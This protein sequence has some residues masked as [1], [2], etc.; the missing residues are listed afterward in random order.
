ME[1]TLPVFKVE[2]AM[3]DFLIRAD[4]QPRGDFLIYL[5]DRAYSYLRFDEVTLL[6]LSAGYQVSTIRQPYLSVNRRSVIYLSVLSTEEA[7]QL[8]VLQTK[9]PVIFYTSWCAIQGDLHVN[10]DARDDDLLDQSR[11]FFAVSNAS[12]FPI[13][14]IT[15]SP[16][17]KVPYVL[18]NRHALTAYHVDSRRTGQANA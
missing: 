9:R 2:V 3:T 6:A 4:F 8:Q 16:A 12:I 13:R 14:S 17:S 7:E 18:I 10:T 11:D 15:Q 1:L 5:N